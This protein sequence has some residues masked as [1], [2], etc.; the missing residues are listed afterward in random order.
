[1][2][3]PLKVIMKICSVLVAL[4]L[5]ATVVCV[6]LQIFTR[7]VLRNP[8]SWTEQMTRL[9]F[10][11]AVF[12]GIPLAFYEGEGFKFDLFVK[13]LGRRVGVITDIV[14]WAV[15]LIFCGYM[16]YWTIVLTIKA[17]SKVTT[18]VEV[19]FYYLYGAI[20]LCMFLLILVI[21]DSVITYF[22]S[23]K[24]KGGGKC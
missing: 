21:L 8:I 7:Y 16:L 15:S 17:G 9:F 18:G 14:A 19:K 24:Q 2:G 22:K 3:K 6:A 5:I 20:A 23:L 4:S 10:V 11:W 1:M 12:L 13:K